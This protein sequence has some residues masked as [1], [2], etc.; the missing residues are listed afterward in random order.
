MLSQI[1]SQKTFGHSRLQ[2]SEKIHHIPMDFEASIQDCSKT[3]EQA[4]MLQQ[5]FNIDF[6]SCVGALIYLSYTR[7]DITFAVNK[8]VKLTRMPGETF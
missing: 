7:P 6:A 1:L 8:L 5:E 2:K 4:E 3:S